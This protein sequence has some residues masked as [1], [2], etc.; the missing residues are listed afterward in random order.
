MRRESPSYG[1]RSAIVGRTFLV[2]AYGCST[3]AF[4]LVSFVSAKFAH[5]LAERR[6]LLLGFAKVLIT[7]CVKLLLVTF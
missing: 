2:G 6:V 1:S 4:P 7:V 3:F 5:L